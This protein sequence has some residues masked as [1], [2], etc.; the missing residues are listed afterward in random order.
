MGKKCA[1]RHGESRKKELGYSLKT[2]QLHLR[3]SHLQETEVR[4][5]WGY[6]HN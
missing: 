4:G 1:L 6:H 3:L 5:R 2:F